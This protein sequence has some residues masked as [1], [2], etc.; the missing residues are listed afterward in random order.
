MNTIERIRAWS[1][2]ETR[3][4][5]CYVIHRANKSIALLHDDIDSRNDTELQQYIE[6]KFNRI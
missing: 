2:D 3:N 6:E 4:G 1:R 5:I